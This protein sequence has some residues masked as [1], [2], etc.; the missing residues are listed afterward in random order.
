[1]AGPFIGVGVGRGGGILNRRII[2]PEKYYLRKLYIFL[3]FV[4]FVF[5]FLFLIFSYEQLIQYFWQVQFHR[6][7]YSTLD[8]ARQPSNLT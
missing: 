2:C 6:P 7:L 3:T 5:L 4:C 8:T 1:M